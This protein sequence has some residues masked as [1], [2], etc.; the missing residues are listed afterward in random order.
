MQVKLDSGSYA[1]A[2]PR[3]TGD[4]STR[5]ISISI[6][7]SG[8]HRILS[9]ATDS[10]SNQAWNSIYVNAVTAADAT[11]PSIKIMSPAAGST[12]PAGAIKVTGTAGDNSGGSGVRTVQV[13]VDSGSY[14]TATPTT[15]DW[16]S[17]S[18]NVNI[19]STGSHRILSR[20]IDNAGN[21]A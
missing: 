3:A 7:T 6:G 5:T 20:A 15:P 21:P 14:A 19:G 8:Q 18:I 13:K 4:W 11:A 2:T 17:W 1:T 16:S 10:A 12:M 9:R